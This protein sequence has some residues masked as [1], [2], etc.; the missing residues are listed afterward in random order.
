[1]PFTLIKSLPVLVFLAT[2]GLPRVH[3][4]TLA[5]LL[6]PNQKPLPV[7]SNGTS[8][9]RAQ[10]GDPGCEVDCGGNTC[11][12]AGWYCDDGGCCPDGE[13][14]GPIIGGCADPNATPCGVDFCCG[15]GSTCD[16]FECVSGGGGGHTTTKKTT[17]KKATTTKKT[18]TTHNTTATTT[19]EDP[20]TTAD[21]DVPTNTASSSSPSVQS[22]PN[23]LP[24]DIG[25]APASTPS[26]GNTNAPTGGSDSG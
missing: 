13:T 4:E 2:S 20:E 22:T 19:T 1:M 21:T 26:I 17:T 6:L 10:I 9:V 3:G 7:A 5:S 25:G 11:C 24:T 15:E 8:P 23:S 12:P 18:T 14:C 16:G